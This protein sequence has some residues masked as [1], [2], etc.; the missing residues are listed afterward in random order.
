M[1]P[2]AQSVDLTLP[3]DFVVS[4]GGVYL[5]APSLTALKT[6]FVQE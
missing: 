3:K 1:D 4:Q 6:V 5:F 2:S